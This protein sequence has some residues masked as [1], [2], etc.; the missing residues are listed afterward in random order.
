MYFSEKG[1][2]FE[3]SVVKSEVGCFKGGFD[4]RGHTV[5][6]LNVG[7]NGLFGSLGG[8]AVVKN[9]ALVNLGVP[10]DG[11]GCGLAFANAAT[12]ENVFVSGNADKLVSYSI[13]PNNRFTDIVA[14]LTG[15]SAVIAKNV[16]SVDT[17]EIVGYG[18]IKDMPYTVR[19]LKFVLTKNTCGR[20][21]KA[22][23]TTL[24]STSA[25]TT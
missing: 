21:A 5:K 4:G 18:I 8:L 10:R 1:N 17:Q 22:I 24:I 20:R 13:G 23:F 6:N 9:L 25:A 19:R 14:E 15:D 7:E 12:I 3:T 16:A 2:I 11:S